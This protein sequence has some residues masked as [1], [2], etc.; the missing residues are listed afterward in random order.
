MRYY[1]RLYNPDGKKLDEAFYKLGYIDTHNFAHLVRCD[2]LLGTGLEDNISPIE[3]Q[4]AVYNNLT[5]PKHHVLFP[6]FT[7]EE[8]QAFDD[9]VIDYFAEVI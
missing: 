5:C 1:S 3:T 6:N 8:I 9:M 4:Y 7:H 2:V